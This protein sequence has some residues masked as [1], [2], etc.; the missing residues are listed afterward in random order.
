MATADSAPAAITWSIRLPLV[1][2]MYMRD[3][4]REGH[5]RVVKR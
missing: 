1:G 3:P 2:S 5:D 4:D